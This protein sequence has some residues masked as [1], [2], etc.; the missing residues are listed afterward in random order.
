MRDLGI[1][2]RKELDHLP[3]L[4]SLVS[5]S[6]LLSSA[7]KENFGNFGKNKKRRERMEGNQLKMNPPI[8]IC[9]RKMDLICHLTQ[10]NLLLTWLKFSL[11]G[12]GGLIQQLK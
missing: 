1:F 7:V 5:I 11:D 10:P 12:T 8:R 2:G 6:S 3:Q 4:P 9:E